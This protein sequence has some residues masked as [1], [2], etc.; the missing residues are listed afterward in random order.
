[1]GLFLPVSGSHAD[2]VTT[3]TC[4]GGGSFTTSG[5]SV[6][7]NAGPSCSGNAVI[8]EGITAIEDYAFVGFDAVSGANNLVSVQFPDSL[9]TIGTAAFLNSGLRNLSIPAG[10]TSIAPQAFQ[11]ALNLRN[12]TIAG[13]PSNP[14]TDLGYYLFNLD[15]LD[16]L[17]LGTGSGR[18]TFMYGMT[19][20]GLAR[21]TDL[22]LGPALT[23]I[24]DGLFAL[25]EPVVASVVFHNNSR[26]V[27][28]GTGLD[29]G[30]G[31]SVG[32]TRTLPAG[33]SLFSIVC[34]VSDDQSRTYQSIAIVDPASGTLQKITS[35]FPDPIHDDPSCYPAP[36]AADTAHSQVYWAGRYWDGVDNRSAL[37][38]FN[39]LGSMITRVGDLILPGTDT[40]FSVGGLA[41]DS[42]SQRLVALGSAGDNLYLGRIDPTTGSVF[43]VIQL[44]KTSGVGL[45]IDQSTSQLAFSF[46]PKDSNF[47]IASRTKSPDGKFHLWS[48]DPGTGTGQDLGE[49]SNPY[50][51]SINDHY[52]NLAID[53]NGV[54]WGHNHGVQTQ[55][56]AG[57]GD[58]NDLKLSAPVSSTSAVV[59][60]F[61]S[62]LPPPAF[63]LSS[64]SES[65]VPGA[66]ISGYSIR[67][68]GG[69]T[70]S[71]SISPAISN[72]LSFNTT[73]GLISGTPTAVATAKTYTITATNSA[74]SATAT[75]SLTVSSVLPPPAFTLSSTSESGAPG[76]AISGYFISSTGGTI[77]SYSISPAIENGLSFNTTTG[78]I[79]GTP[80]AVATAKTYTITA[81]NS[82]GSA[83]ATYSLTVNADQAVAEA[84]A[85]SAA[86]AAAK[87][88]AEAAAKREAE[89][90][91]ARSDIT[92][93]LKS[94]KDLTVDA[95]AKA[96]IPGI[97]ATN[98]AAVQ[99]ELL[100]LPESS[101]TDI[102][103]VLKIAHKYEV[104]GNIGSD[105]IK[106]MQSNSFVEIGLIPA[107]SKNKGAL[108]LAIRKLTE[109]SRDTYAEIKAAIDAATKEIQV[110]SDRLAAIIARNSTR[111]KK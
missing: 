76:A 30:K 12:V 16:S 90:Q 20:L 27:L 22:T 79:S 89:K 104:V 42:I 92:T 102:N 38:K 63:T 53:S 77:A 40:Q 84:A 68:T 9:Q 80:T 107:D 105:Q 110:R 28:T 54:L 93:K 3:V 75:Y 99:A 19:L 91:S 45:F 97:T 57:W 29:L 52:H 18:L 96:E 24:P 66:A 37:F 5:N 95:F 2:G 49:A 26:T 21:I 71:F 74:G 101:R 6:L 48:I 85:K 100:A 34:D 39:F 78:L 109:A 55:T 81:T 98:I 62:V 61:I 15:S 111:Y 36:S 25:P 65:G 108:V 103:Q 70:T 43:N 87:S 73:T 8:P 69:P 67:S 14:G 33:K 59:S 1:V 31:F 17:V 72:G 44:D 88:V 11:G 50:F 13:N 46:N 58:D 83:T 60:L 41:F 23:S 64:T 94:A 56:I 32:Q 51:S 47:I 35:P 82:A 106:Y 86:E 4:S 10:V 7:R